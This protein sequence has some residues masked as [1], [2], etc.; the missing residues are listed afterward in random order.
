[1]PE[2]KNKNSIVVWS[3]VVLVIAIA[4][5]GLLNYV[6]KDSVVE[7]APIALPVA[8][9]VAPSAIPEVSPTPVVPQVN[10][11]YKEGTYSVTGNYNSPGG[12]EEVGVKVTVKNDMITDAV[13]EV[14]ATRPTSVKWQTAFSS[15]VKE[16]VMGKKLDEVKLDKV[17][18][19]S[20]TPKGWNEAIGEI[21][22]Q[23]K[24]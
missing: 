16:A 23:A 21:Q 18:G 17:S 12:A 5:Y 2:E 20:L 8:P 10:F 4:A 19:S 24:A 9:T 3:I 6:R 15:G 22:V 1:M 13:V 14:R 7:E 11:K